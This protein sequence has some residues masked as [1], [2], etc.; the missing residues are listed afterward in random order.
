MP[1]QDLIQKSIEVVLDL[2]I[3]DVA[4]GGT[5]MAQVEAMEGPRGD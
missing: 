2:D 5:V 1:Y 4:F 3:P